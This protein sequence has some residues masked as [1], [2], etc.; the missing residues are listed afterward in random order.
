[1][2]ASVI[3]AGNDHEHSKGCSRE[4]GN[5]VGRK[6]V[7]GQ[8]KTNGASDFKDRNER[9]DFVAHAGEAEAWT[10]GMDNDLPAVCK[11]FAEAGEEE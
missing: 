2:A 10:E 4:A 6:Q 3:H 1:M 8:D 9:N 7:D 11:D 5:Y